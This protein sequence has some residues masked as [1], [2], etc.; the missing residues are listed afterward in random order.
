MLIC[1]LCIGLLIIIIIIILLYWQL[2][3]H[4]YSNGL[5]YLVKQETLDKFD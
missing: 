2:Y 1:I 3:M 5:L 4:I